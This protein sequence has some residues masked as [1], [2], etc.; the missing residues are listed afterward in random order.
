MSGTAAIN[1]QLSKSV[2][3]KATKLQNICGKLKMNINKV[4]CI[5]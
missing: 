4:K 2:P 3:Y 1:V 5:L